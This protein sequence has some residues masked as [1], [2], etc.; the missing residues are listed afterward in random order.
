MFNGYLEKG[1]ARAHKG[2]KK[3]KCW[4]GKAQEKEYK[5][6]SKTF[7]KELKIKQKLII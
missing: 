1:L 5:Y 3:Q 4:V 6:K 7:F 2:E